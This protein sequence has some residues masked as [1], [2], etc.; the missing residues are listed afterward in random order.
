MDY[1]LS[2]IYTS[3]KSVAY[4]IGGIR[5][6]AFFITNDEQLQQKNEAAILTMQAM[7]PGDFPFISDYCITLLFYK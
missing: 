7:L 2:A 6:V 4:V 3:N 5:G 1:G